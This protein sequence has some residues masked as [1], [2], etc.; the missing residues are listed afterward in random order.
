MR[1]V[2]YLNFLLTSPLIVAICSLSFGQTTVTQNYVVTNTVKQS[3][4][5]TQTSVNALTISTQGKSQSI[6]Y[7][8]GLGRPLQTVLTN[9]SASQKDLVTPFECTGPL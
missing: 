3:G 2:K 6:I 9:A 7:L 4:V 1:N 8:D 5:T